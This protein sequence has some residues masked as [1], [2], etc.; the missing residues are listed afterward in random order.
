MERWRGDGR[1]R[2]AVG[3]GAVSIEQSDSEYRLYRCSIGHDPSPF[4]PN[5][6]DAG[7]APS[8][9]EL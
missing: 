2:Q 5:R 7:R 9:R 1:S 3:M 8:Q 4:P 6:R